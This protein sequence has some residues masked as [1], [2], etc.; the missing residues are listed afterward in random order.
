MTVTR[1]NFHAACPGLSDRAL[2][3]S[4]FVDP[5]SPANRYN[6][7]RGSIADLHRGHYDH[8]AAVGVGFCNA[9]GSN[10]WP[11]GSPDTRLD[12]C[13]P[14]EAG[15]SFYYLL[16]GEK[17]CAGTS[18]ASLRGIEGSTGTNRFYNPLIPEVERPIGTGCQ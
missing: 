15:P 2:V 9:P 8:V 5:F 4:W 14:D 13:D 6:M 1:D 12:F 18:P 3:F 17:D 16:T 10:F 7:Y 11:V